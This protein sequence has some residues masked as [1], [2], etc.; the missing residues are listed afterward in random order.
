[1]KYRSVGDSFT[2][3]AVILVTLV[4]TAANTSIAVAAAADV[5]VVDIVDSAKGFQL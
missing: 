5:V 3:V 1:M 2:M 4:V